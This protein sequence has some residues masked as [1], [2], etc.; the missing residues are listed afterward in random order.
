MPA[1]PKQEANF[2][3]VRDAVVVA[4]EGEKEVAGAFDALMDVAIEEHD[5]LSRG[6]IQWFV[7]EQLEEVSMM[8]DLLKVVERADD[9]LLYVEEYV[10]RRPPP[11]TPAQ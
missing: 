1:I 4:L 11:R 3:S 10:A 8:E 2:G 5:H 7:N 9:N 6:F